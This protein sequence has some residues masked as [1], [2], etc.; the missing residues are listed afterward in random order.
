MSNLMH[1]LFLS[2]KKAF[3]MCKYRKECLISQR[4][5]YSQQASSTQQGRPLK[6]KNV[7]FLSRPPDDSGYDNIRHGPRSSYSCCCCS[8]CWAVLCLELLHATIWYISFFFPSPSHQRVPWAFCPCWPLIFSGILVLLIMALVTSFFIKKSLKVPS[9]NMVGFCLWLVLRS[10]W[11][12][13]TMGQREPH[14][15]LEVE[16]SSWE[17][18]A[19]SGLGFFKSD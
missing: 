3:V 14:T 6:N 16:V 12:Y 9:W 1:T 7:V 15:N 17:R 8:F 19:E 11:K 10:S 18:L 2:K 5:I 4:P 13:R